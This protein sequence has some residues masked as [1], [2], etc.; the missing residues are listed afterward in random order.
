MQFCHLCYWR[1]SVTGL[2]TGLETSETE[3]SFPLPTEIG[4]FE[5]WQVN[6][7]WIAQ[8]ISPGLR[9]FC[10]RENALI[11][12]TDWSKNAWDCTFISVTNGKGEVKRPLRVAGSIGIL[13]EQYE[14][15]ICTE[16]QSF[17]TR[18]VANHECLAAVF[19]FHMSNDANHFI[20]PSQGYLCVFF[21]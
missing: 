11:W 21:P 4:L 14:L 17:Y 10:W 16:S 8:F 2:Q 7:L 12:I 13:S 3:L 19:V 5:W 1:G 20:R 18:Y 9:N 15:H 6:S